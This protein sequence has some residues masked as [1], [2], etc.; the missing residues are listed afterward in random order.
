VIRALV[1]AAI[2]AAIVPGPAH[3]QG[4]ESADTQTVRA[5]Q[6]DSLSM[7]ASEFYGDRSKYPFII[8]ENRIQKPRPL[9]QGQRLRIPVIREITTSPG[10]TFAKLAESYLGDPRRAGFLAQANQM[11]PDD[12]LA[13]GVPLLVPFT[14]TYTADGKESLSQIAGTYYN[15]SK[16]G[17]AL[18]DY[19]FLDANVIQK[20]ETITIPSLN[21]RMHPS[22]LGKPS[23]EAR[24]RRERHRD[25]NE[26]A[27][28]AIPAA[29]HAWRL[30]NYAEVKRLLA[31]IDVEYVDVSPAIEV[32]LLL[33]SALVAFKDQDAALAAFRKVLE[34]RPGLTLRKVDHS[35][36]I[37]AV[38]TKADGQIE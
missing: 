17:D 8:T 32:G 24:A 22:K 26:R 34:R 36:K 38:W 31:D 2:V 16:L 27:A 1:L 15:D 9:Y 11:S 30:G 23:A 21:V 29:R 28:K 25:N 10:D 5:K 19:N 3:A 14:I 6:N 37:L 33:G 12:S 18:R 35:P 4:N 20:G 7:L 13:A